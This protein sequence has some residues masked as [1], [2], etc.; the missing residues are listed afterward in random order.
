[1]HSF[2]PWKLTPKV[3]TGDVLILP[4]ASSDAVTQPLL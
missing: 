3:R 4:F 1:M 2:T